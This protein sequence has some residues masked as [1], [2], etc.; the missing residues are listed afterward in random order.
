MRLSTLRQPGVG[1][2]TQLEKAHLE[3]VRRYYFDKAEECCVAAKTEPDRLRKAALLD[4]AKGWITLS[5][6]SASQSVH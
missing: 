1:A 5:E 3:T 2:L 6:R 4:M